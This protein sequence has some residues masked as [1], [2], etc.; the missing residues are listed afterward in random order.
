M[1]NKRRFQ[2]PILEHIHIAK[3]LG[4]TLTWGEQ[5]I[6]EPVD[7]FADIQA[8]AYD[9]KIKATMKR[10]KNKRRITLDSSI[11]ITTEEKLLNTEHGKTFELI[12]VGMAIIDAMLDRERRDEK[13]LEHL[14]HLEKYYQDSTQATVSLRSEFQNSYTKF[15]SER[16]LFTTGI[17]DFQ[18]DTLMALATY[19]DMEG[20]YEKSH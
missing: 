10:T 9:R 13:E 15:T 3:S 5:Q 7:E 12:D 17:A 2:E 19:K 11:L 18:E 1:H 14:L 16:H 8:I 6:P 20:W 4:D